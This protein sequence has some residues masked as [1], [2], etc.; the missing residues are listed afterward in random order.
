MFNFDEIINNYIAHAAIFIH[1]MRK[2]GKV[3][4]KKKGKKGKMENLTRE[5]GNKREKNRNQG[6]T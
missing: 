2:G 1:V 3:K 6:R 4:R 5:N